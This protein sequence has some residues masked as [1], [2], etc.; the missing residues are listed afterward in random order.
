MHFK[1]MVFH[2]HVESVGR[3]IPWNSQCNFLPRG[4]VEKSAH[5]RLLKED[6]SEYIYGRVWVLVKVCLS[7]AH[8]GWS[9]FWNYLTLSI[10]EICKCC[11]LDPSAFGL[12]H[13]PSYLRMEFTKE[14]LHFKK[15]LRLHSYKAHIF[16]AVS[17]TKQ[18]T[19]NP[20]LA[21]PTLANPTSVNIT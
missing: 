1:W 12:S 13:M 6:A 10:E 19:V 9:G 15:L 21:N 3:I 2:V 18:N 4:L 14:C 16:T 11:P 20:T 7:N 5:S 8:S 17:V